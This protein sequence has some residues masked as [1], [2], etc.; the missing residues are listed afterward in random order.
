MNSRR[1]EILGRSSAIGI[2]RSAVGGVTLAS[3][4]VE[5][6]ACLLAI[7]AAGQCPDLPV[8]RLPLGRRPRGTPRRL[9]MS[10]GRT[11]AT[12]SALHDRAGT[13]AAADPNDRQSI[14]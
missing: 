1:F 3:A 8:P 13:T 11:A 9:T 14:R 12:A 10:A 6:M 2:G 5:L 4:C 7:G